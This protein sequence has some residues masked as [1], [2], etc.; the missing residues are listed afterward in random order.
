[1]MTENEIDQEEQSASKEGFSNMLRDPLTQ[2]I[3][4]LIPP[5]EP[6]ELLMNLLKATWDRGFS[7]GSASLAKMFLKMTK[8]HPKKG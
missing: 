1:M 3:I 4:S 5:T 8:E 7:H 2:V 6:P